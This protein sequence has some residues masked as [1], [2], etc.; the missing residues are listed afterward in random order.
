MIKPRKDSQLLA[1]REQPAAQWKEPHWRMC[2]PTVGGSFPKEGD[3]LSW[4]AWDLPGFPTEKSQ[5]PRNLSPGH[6][7]MVG[8]HVPRIQLY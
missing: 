5:V 3:Q 2:S 4:F 6:L 8:H 7:E 1:Q